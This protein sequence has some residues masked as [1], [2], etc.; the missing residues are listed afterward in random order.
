MIFYLFFSCFHNF[1]IVVA[2]DIEVVDN[3]G[4]GSVLGPLLEAAWTNDLPIIYSLN[5]KKLGTLVGQ[6]GHSRGCS[7]FGLVDVDGTC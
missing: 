3:G 7:V 6:G 2:P 1:Q 4:P 5:R